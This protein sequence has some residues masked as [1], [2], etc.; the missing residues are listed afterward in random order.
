[1]SA[2]EIKASLKQGVKD[3]EVTGPC[4]CCA[5]WCSFCPCCPEGTVPPKTRGLNLKE[6]EEA[7][8]EEEEEDASSDEEEEGCAAKCVIS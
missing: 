7:A 8:V 4:M 2:A 5:R 1:M 6:E 3:G